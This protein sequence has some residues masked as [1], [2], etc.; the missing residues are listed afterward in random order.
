MGSWLIHELRRV[1]RDQDGHEMEWN[2]LYQLASSAPAF[3]AF[4][5]PDCPAFYNPSNMEQAITEFCRETGQKS[6]EGKG[7][8]LRTVYESLALKYRE[9][10]EDIVR[11]CKKPTKVVH[12]VGGGSRNEMLNQFTA[13]SLGLPVLAGPVEATAV[14]NLMVQAIGCGVVSSLHQAMP[15]IK[16]AFP[17]AS[18]KPQN[19]VE[20]EKAYQKFIS[21]AKKKA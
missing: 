10:N 15:I 4:I 2:E 17:I 16:K 13:N 7:S 6:P 8:F 20:W 9:V 3:S 19:A 12:I 11:V 21:I 18:Y 1:W 5:D 14:G